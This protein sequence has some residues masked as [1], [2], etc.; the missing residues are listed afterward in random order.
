MTLSPILLA[1]YA[2]W[3]VTGLG[4]ALWIW[5]WVRVKDPIARLRFQDCGVV[6][7]FAAVLTRIIIQ[8]RQMTVFDWA[9]I[10]LGPLFIAAALWRLS[11]TQP[12]KR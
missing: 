12:V 2:S 9:M 6:L 3:A 1:F 10:L 7:V 4:V 5:S 11:R 8:D